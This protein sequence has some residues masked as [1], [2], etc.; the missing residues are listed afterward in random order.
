MLAAGAL[1]RT[2]AAAGSRTWGGRVAA[3]MCKMLECVPQDGGARVT[4]YPEAGVGVPEYPVS[5]PPPAAAAA[6]ARGGLPPL[7]WVVVGVLL[8]KGFDLVRSSPHSQVPLCVHVCR[9]GSANMDPCCLLRST[10]CAAAL[11]SQEDELSFQHS[12][13]Q[14]MIMRPRCPQASKLFKGGPSNMGNNV[15]GMMMEQMMKQMM[16]GKGGPMGGM[17]GMD[18]NSNPFAAMANMGGA[19]GAGAGGAGA[20]N[21]WA[22]MPPFPGQQQQQQQGGSPSGFPPPSRSAGLHKRQDAYDACG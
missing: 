7:V 4:S 22:N 12:L 17:G 1:C 6:Q 14:D 10:M 15:Q 21:P 13:V 18:P 3:N 5:L 11:T 19:G 9:C 8:A 16:S 2:A 20:A